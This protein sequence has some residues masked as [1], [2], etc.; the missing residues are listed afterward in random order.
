MEEGGVEAKV[1]PIGETTFTK[2]TED[3]VFDEV[4]CHLE[5]GVSPDNLE[6][7]LELSRNVA[8][9]IILF[10][11]E[12]FGVTNATISLAE[13]RKDKDGEKEPYR[14]TLIIGE[15]S[16][17]EKM[18]YLRGAVEDGK[19]VGHVRSTVDLPLPVEGGGSADVLTFDDLLSESVKKENGKLTSELRLEFEKLRNHLIVSQKL[20]SF[21]IEEREG[22]NKLGRGGQL[23]WG[24]GWFTPLN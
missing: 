23:K 15:G 13:V 16:D 17:N 14:L 10:M 22:G 7:D 19:D 2:F 1:A 20:V 3:L 11:K 12:G 5:L 9:K 24:E 8:E 21:Y 6:S 18:A 4:K